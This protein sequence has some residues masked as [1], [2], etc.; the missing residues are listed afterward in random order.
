MSTNNQYAPPLNVGS[1]DF[2]TETSNGCEGPASQISI[3]TT[4]TP[5]APTISGTVQYCEGDSPTPLVATQ[6]LGGQIDWFNS[7]DINVGTGTSYTPGL[8]T[9][10]STFYAYETF[11]GCSS[12]STEVI[13]NVDAA[14]MVDAPATLSLCAGDSAQV[15]AVNNGYAIS[16]STSQTGET[17][18]IQ[19]DTTTLVYVIATN[20]LCGFAQDSIM[21]TVNDLPDI[22]AGNDTL[23]GIGGE[24][25][26]WANSDETLNYSWSPNPDECQ[27][28]TCN[29]IYD[30]PDQATIYVV[31]GTDANGCINRDTVF[32][33][34][35]GYMDVFVPNIFSPNGDGW[36][37]LLEIKGP[38]LFNYQIEIYDRWGK[39]VFYSTEQKNYW[40]GTFNGSNLAPQTFVYLL[41]GETVLGERITQEGN[42]SIIK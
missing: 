40:D 41:S 2:V 38:R 30:V 18:F 12:D 9:G 1:F 34:I 3:I 14:P 32:V 31:T 19:L 4:P 29:L 6:D 28:D 33:D 37:D 20:P 7:L 22:E 39:K 25:S 36:N 17:V 21:V 13:I 11:N 15:T 35:N 26:L 24:V 8:N 16:W 23:I 27:N 10:T 5:I 42:V